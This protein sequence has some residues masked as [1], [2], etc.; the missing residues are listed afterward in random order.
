MIVEPTGCL[1]LAGLKKIIKEAEEGVSDDVEGAE[2]E[3]EKP[4]PAP[5]P[6]VRKPAAPAVQMA[7][8]PST[9]I[10][11]IRTSHGGSGARR[12]NR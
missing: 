9:G 10:E 2:D 11:V 5:K 12:G 4:R 7:P 1:G 8:T 3:E 6:A